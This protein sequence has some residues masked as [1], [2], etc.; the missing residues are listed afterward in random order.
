VTERTRQAREE[1]AAGSA[2]RSV[3]PRPARS[4]L[5]PG[6]VLAYQ[7]N[8]TL[9]PVSLYEGSE[10][11]QK[12][13]QPAFY[14]AQDR[15]EM[16]N[17]TRANDLAKLVDIGWDLRQLLARQ[18]IQHWDRQLATFA[19]GLTEPEYRKR[20]AATFDRLAA[21]KAARAS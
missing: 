4:D 19:E 14:L 15:T 21:R 12:K 1:A 17:A 9:A 8:F 11:A 6:Q 3:E 10:G 16:P 2:Q 13:G 7:R 5:G 18:Q 20:L